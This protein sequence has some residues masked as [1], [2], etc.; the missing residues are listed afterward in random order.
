MEASMEAT[1]IAIS[2]PASMK[3]SIEDKDTDSLSVANHEMYSTPVS[4]S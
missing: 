3:A 4:H 1:F 2:T